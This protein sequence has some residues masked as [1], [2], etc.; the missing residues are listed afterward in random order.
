MTTATKKRMRRYR[1][2]KSLQAKALVKT[3][4]GMSLWSYLDFG[5]MQLKNSKTNNLS[6]EFFFPMEHAVRLGDILDKLGTP[7]ELKMT[8]R[9]IVI[10]IPKQPTPEQDKIIL[11][12][13]KVF[14]K[15]KPV[16]AEE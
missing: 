14:K 11:E 12:R 13:L 9:Y 16:E 4:E 2:R 5:L 15:L 10:H 7:M 3:L 8:K 6:K 1:A